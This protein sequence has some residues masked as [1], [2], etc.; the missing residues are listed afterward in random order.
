M[1]T[2]TGHNPI[3][4]DPPANGQAHARA[5]LAH[6]LAGLCLLTGAA[7]AAPAGTPNDTP[8]DPVVQQSL[9]SDG[10]KLDI[11]ISP[12][13]HGRDALRAEQ[14]VN[15]E[16]RFSYADTGEPLIGA[17]PAA[18]LDRRMERLFWQERVLGR[19]GKFR[20]CRSR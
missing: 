16:L 18:W 6:V 8:I 2:N 4:G 19:S 17:Y 14:S 1:M 9:E 10:L 15:L 13:V 20:L 7:L 12:A 3:A 5:P 11:A